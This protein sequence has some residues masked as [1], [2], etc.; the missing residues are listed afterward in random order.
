MHHNN[1]VAYKHEMPKY[2][3]IVKTNAST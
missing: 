1:V 3:K 2:K